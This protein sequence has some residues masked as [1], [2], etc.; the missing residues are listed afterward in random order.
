MGLAVVGLGALAG[1]EL[2]RG[3]R[4]ADLERRRTVRWLTVLVALALVVRFTGLSHEAL[5]RY[6][7]DEGTYYHH[8]AKINEG[9]PFRPSFVY[10]HFLYYSGA[11]VLWAVDLVPGWPAFAKAVLGSADPLGAAW[12]A[13]RGINAF[14]GALVVIPVFFLGRRLGGGLGAGALAAGLVIASPL[15][16]EFSH[17]IISDLP[18]AVF[19]AGVAALAAAALD[20]ER[21]SLYAGAGVAAGLAAVSKY[22]AGVAAIAILAVWLAARWRAR[23]WNWGLVVAG[24]T[25]LAAFFAFLPSLFVFPTLALTGERGIFFGARQYSQGGWIGVQPA[26]NS[27]F[28]LAELADDLGLAAVA[29]GVAGLAIACLRPRTPGDRLRV[30]VFAVFPLVY[31][32]LI[33][34][35]NMVVRRNALPLIPLAAVLAAVGVARLAETRPLVRL[36]RWALPALAVAVLALPAWATLRQAVGFARPSTR[37]V[38]RDWIRAHVPRGSTLVK[39]SYTPEID[40]AEYRLVKGRFAARLA[41]EELRSPAHDYLVLADSAFQRFLSPDKTREE[42]HEEYG[43]RY[44][45]IFATFPEVARFEPTPWRRGPTILVLRVPRGEPAR[46]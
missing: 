1:R 22:P 20:R 32:A 11:L 27:G 13:L 17:L 8:A 46:P 31:F 45:E 24:S 6:Y 28:Y 29:L 7:L 37:D 14:L 23:S 41:L 21:T 36:G 2:G 33:G 38:A 25:A 3:W 12:L 40:P 44:R 10:P 35:M 9:E 5:G 18:A 26:S 30:A 43:R 16:N 42:H 15:V 4:A 34:S 19:A 39:E